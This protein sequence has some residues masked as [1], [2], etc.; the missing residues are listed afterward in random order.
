LDRGSDY[1]LDTLTAT[2]DLSAIPR[3]LQDSN[4]MFVFYV[5]CREKASRKYRNE[6]RSIGSVHELKA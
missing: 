6:S 5:Y 3:S 4:F 2:S 1:E